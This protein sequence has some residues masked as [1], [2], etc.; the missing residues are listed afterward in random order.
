M[1]EENSSKQMETSNM[2]RAYQREWLKNT[3]ERVDQGEPFVIC[4]GADFEENL[5]IMDIPVMVIN[6]WHALIGVK[7]MVNY[8]LKILAEHGYPQWTFGVGLASTIDRK[9]DIAPWGGL[10]KPTVIIAGTRKDNE[11][12]VLELW[13]QE[14]GCPLW[15]LEFGFL[16]GII[17]SPG[18]R[19]WERMRNH[20]D[21]FIDP[22]KL[23]FRVEEEKRLIR[24]LEVST[25]KKFSMGKLYHAMEL[26]N[27]QMDYW[28]KAR[29][30]IAETIPCPVGLRDQLAIYQTEWHR[31]TT[32]GR[33]L[34][35]AYYEEVKE[36]VDKGIAAIPNEK[37]RLMWLAGTPPAWARWAEETY[38]A[39][40]VA[41]EFSAIPIDSYPRTILNNDPMRTLAGR[42]MLLFWRTHDWLPKEAKLHHCDGVIAPGPRP[43]VAV[44]AFEEVGMPLL[45]LP[46]V[47]NYRDDAEIRSLVSK[48]IETRL[49]PK[50]KA[51]RN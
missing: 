10:P 30:L 51:K 7:Q 27:E 44:Q 18:P 24:Y 23:D 48:F 33:D 42:H 22:E 17:K 40:C 6:Y 2:V 38:G 13:A 21:E 11:L 1:S 46:P 37:L 36:R 41:A 3:R 28:K 12:R 8:Y 31:G 32:K 4:H 9:P 14:F 29:D 39:V 19:W 15:P 25:G 5:N 35:K 20:W 43:Q 50:R 45:Q 47:S 49:L 34:V 16:H 26:V